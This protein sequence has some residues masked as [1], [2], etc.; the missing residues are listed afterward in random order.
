MRVHAD[1]AFIR[2]GYQGFLQ[3]VGIRQGAGAVVQA[4]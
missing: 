2:K 3:D 1:L 4:D